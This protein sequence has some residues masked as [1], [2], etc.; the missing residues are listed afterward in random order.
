[1][2]YSGKFAT[3]KDQIIEVNIVTNNDSSEETELMFADDSPVMI[4]QSSSDGVF[5]AI[6]SRACTITIL[7]KE[8]YLDIYSASSQGTTIEVTNLTTSE[9]LFFGYVTPCEYNQELQYL[10]ELEI[11][12]VD[13]L[14]SL[15]DINFSY[16]NASNPSIVSFLTLVTRAFNVAGYSGKL[17]LQYKGNK[18][19]LASENGWLPME[20][21]YITEEAFVDDEPMKWYD[22]LTE[23]LNF[24]GLS[25]IPK[26]DDVY[27]VDYNVISNEI[28][29][30]NLYKDI[31]H[32]TQSVL[33]NKSVYFVMNSGSG[34]VYLSNLNGRTI[35]YYPSSGTVQ[36]SRKLHY[37]EYNT[38]PLLTIAKGESY[39]LW[40]AYDHQQTITNATIKSALKPM[41]VYGTTYGSNYVTP[42]VTISKDSYAGDNQNVEMDE[43]YN[44]ISIKSDVDEIEDDKFYVDILDYVHKAAYIK[45]NAFIYNTWWRYAKYTMFS[46]DFSYDYASYRIYDRY[47][48]FT[49]KRINNKPTNNYWQ[50][51]T[52]TNVWDEGGVIM[53]VPCLHDKFSSQYL[54]YM[55]IDQ[56]PIMNARLARYEYQWCTINQQFG[57]KQGEEMPIKVDW[58]PY[59]EFHTGAEVWARYYNDINS[60]WTNVDGQHRTTWN[61][62]VSQYGTSDVAALWW[63]MYANE[64]MVKPV[65]KYS[66]DTNINYSPSSNSKIN[67]IC[68]KGDL[69][70]Q[71]RGYFGGDGKYLHKIYVDNT[72]NK[73]YLSFPL[74]DAGYNGDDQL[75]ASR[76]IGYSDYNKGWNSLK[77]KL[78]IGDK[79]WNGSAWT[80]SDSDFWIPYHKKNVNGD[81]ET[82]IWYGWN[83]PVTNHTFES[84]INEDCFAI[85][86][87]Y[88][89]CVMGKIEFS[90]YTPMTHYPS[91][92]M[93]NN[94]GNVQINTIYTVPV[95]FMKD[96]SIK[97]V[98][99]NNNGEDGYIWI[100]DI[101]NPDEE[102]DIIYS[103][104][105]DSN[106]VMEFDELSLKVA[107]YNDK[108]PL[109][110][111]FVI[112]PTSYGSSNYKLHTDG[113]VNS[114]K[115]ITQR[116]EQNIIDKYFN[117]H[118]S[119][120]LIYNC[121]VHNYFEPYSVVKTTVFGDNHK[122]VVDEQEYDIK[123]NV[124][125]LK[126]VEL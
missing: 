50:C 93:E 116:Q 82:L 90:I 41:V 72:D 126:L 68:F 106:N 60:G 65:L 35:Y 59:I 79:Y 92:A 102:D 2:K 108:K 20:N 89:D 64:L 110:Q 17:Y 91:G 28:S 66:G 22:V 100:N 107:T 101:K 62:K 88:D 42:D 16:Q 47:F 37:S 31:S 21:E 52:N 18:S 33:D 45:K 53:K 87:K 80:T 24:Y 117:H 15:Q 84:G 61:S 1:M 122:F 94:N 119:P 23:I 124:N 29:D 123:N 43:V 58:Q 77:C 12:A 63:N 6:K 48:Y 19:K 9:K 75:I 120:K 118:K 85:P 113:F 109:S 96:L 99:T 44:K 73:E 10:N 30:Y 38:T 4:T 115:G 97:F 3:T 51:Y 13:A 34:D 78:K 57:F 71:K 67:Y 39:V 111:S 114:A 81:N 14:S 56:T 8:I 55:D 103:N 83:K 98:S 11:E 69:L 95:V 46:S 49:S 40:D 36:D 26:G 27:L 7:T 125:E 5:S 74:V 70:W 112:Q 105:I 32:S 104:T 86:I 121:Q 76:A 54:N 25:A